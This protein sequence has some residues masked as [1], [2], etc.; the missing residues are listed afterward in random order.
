MYNLFSRISS[1]PI[2]EQMNGTAPTTPTEKSPAPSLN[3]SF[4][5]TPST[6]SNPPHLTNGPSEDRP[7]TPQGSKVATRT[8]PGERGPATTSR[9]SKPG[10]TRTPA[11]SAGTRSGLP[12][13]RKT[14]LN[15]VLIYG[16]F[17]VVV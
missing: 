11:G 4:N 15:Q 2:E 16:D 1:G 17:I 7:K 13:S 9:V 6:Q 12:T 5:S 10:T 8:K 14:S 3:N